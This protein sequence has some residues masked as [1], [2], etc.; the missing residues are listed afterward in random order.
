MAFI[1]DIK[2]SYLQGSML[3]RLIF[4]NIGVFLLL[5]VL[6]LGALLVNV[7]GGEV[8]QWL[9]LPS[10]LGM[11]LRRPW[12]EFP[13]SIV[14]SAAIC[15]RLLRRQRTTCIFI[16]TMMRCRPTRVRCIT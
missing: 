13:G 10:D 9:E 4:I 15:R 6:A 12:S 1:D 7:Q 14:S 5:H 2:R 8:L 16:T 11:L 3:L